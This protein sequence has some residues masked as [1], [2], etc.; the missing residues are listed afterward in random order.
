MADNLQAT[1]RR[2]VTENGFDP[3]FGPDVQRQL[4]SQPDAAAFSSDVGNDA[5]DLRDLLWSSIDN[6]ESLDLDQIEV[7]E[8]LPDGSIRITVGIADVDVLVGR[9][10]PVDEH[11][12]HN[13][14]S[15]YTGVAIFP[16][17]PEALSTAR[18][19]LLGQ[20]DRF[21]IAIEVVVGAAGEVVSYDAYRAIVRNKA[22]LAYDPVGSWLD[23]G[24]MPPS[25]SQVP[26]LAEQLQ[27]QHEAAKRLK[28]QRERSGALDLD[29]IETRPIV[30]NGKIVDLAVTRDNPARDLIEDFMIAANG[31]IARFLEAHG[32]SGI[33]R[34]VRE[35][36]RWSRIVELAGE[37]GE[38][39]PEGP[40]SIALSRFLAQRKIADPLR[41]PDLSLAIIKLLGP[42]EYA[43][44]RPGQDPGGHFG[45]AAHDYT[46]ATAPNRRYADLV[47]QRLVKA[48]LVG[49]AQPYSDDELTAIAAHCTER[50]DAARK[51]ERTMRKIAAALLL[52]DRIGQNF[53][54]IVTG[55]TP[56]GTFVRV[57]TP[58]AEG[59]LLRGDQHPD[60]GDRVRVKLVSVDPQKGYIDF[61]SL[62]VSRLSSN[63]VSS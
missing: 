36:E 33:R 57:L 52:R 45:L 7:A 51:V 26:G 1:A 4:A 32:S 63:R 3:D 11:A 24:A 12:A 34:V 46:H 8:R 2:V 58:P 22:K 37:Y 23:G 31:A 21:A 60:V 56:K 48:V 30:Q 15:V 44:D 14:T 61:H 6:D 49:A 42:G 25:I 19:S 28:A 59:L 35:P 55:V 13:A 20:Q 10:T 62:G 40:D 53:D 5:R 29:T 17:L 9:H 41:F 27:L 38:R 43:L 54:A 18:T 39:L 50:E 16:M 47:T